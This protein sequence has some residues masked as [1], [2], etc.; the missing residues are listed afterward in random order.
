[1]ISDEMFATLLDPAVVENFH[2]NSP[3]RFYIYEND[4]VSDVL[5]HGWVWEQHMHRLFER[6]VNFDSVVLDGGANIGAHTV[7]LSKLAKHVHAFEPLTQTF[8]L[9]SRNLYI[10]ECSNVTAYPQALGDAVGSAFFEW[11]NEGNI[12]GSG[13]AQQGQGLGISAPMTTID[14]Q[15]FD[16]LD[17]IKLDLEQYEPQAIAGAMQTIEKFH[18]TIALECWSVYPEHSLGNTMRQYKDLLD[19]GYNVYPVGDETPDYV[20][21]HRD[22]A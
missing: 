14:A 17:F 13:L 4:F 22:R 1:M 10:N 11:I 16:Q 19:L 21:I 8:G 5:A 15:D 12:G 6:H 20:F 2:D 18:P 3:A 7:K 9:L